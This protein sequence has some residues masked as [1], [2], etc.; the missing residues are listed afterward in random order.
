MEPNMSKLEVKPENHKIF[1]FKKIFE[2][3]SAKQQAEKK[4]LNA[5]GM[6][7]KFNPLKRPT[8]ET[9]LLKEQ[10]LRYE[11][12]WFVAS[13][14]ILNYT[15]AVTYPI[16]VHNPHAVSLSIKNDPSQNIYPVARQNDKTKVDMP[17]IEHC[18][19]V[20]EFSNY[21]DGLKREVKTQVFTDYIKKFGHNE[22]EQ[23]EL[24]NVLQ[25]IL[26]V[27]SLTSI[28]RSELQNQVINASN[29]EEDSEEITSLYLYF[30]PVYAFEYHW[31][32]A[33][34]VGVIEVDGLTG[35]IIENGNWFKNTFDQTFTRD[36]LI[37]LSAELASTVVPGAGT[38]VKIANKVITQ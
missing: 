12:F 19:R 18:H 34:K 29:I 27:D 5:F 33:D 38:V 26:S 6:F 8:D 28:V 4:K 23:V 9:V 32:T 3:E 16:P 20:V 30:R 36:N 10:I 35:E 7:A 14:R 1:I 15:C 22:V 25:P 21:F 17:V 37:E 24:E 31:S 11:P 2:F 13:K